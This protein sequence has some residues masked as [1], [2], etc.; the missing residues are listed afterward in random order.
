[1]EVEKQGPALDGRLR[2]GGGGGGG[3]A[4]RRQHREGRGGGGAGRWRWRR[5]AEAERRESGVGTRALATSAASVPP[6]SPLVVGDPEFF[7]SLPNA[8]QGAA[9]AFSF[10]ILILGV[11]LDEMQKLFALESY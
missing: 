4:R 11:C 3:A 8:M 5:E 10:C 7:P 2:E 6:V 1:M 9:A